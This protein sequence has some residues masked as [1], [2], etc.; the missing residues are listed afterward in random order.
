MIPRNLSVIFVIPHRACAA[1][2]KL[3][4]FILTNGGIENLRQLKRNIHCL[5]R[6]ELICLPL[7]DY[8]IVCNSSIC[9]CCINIVFF[10]FNKYLQITCHF[11]VWH[12]QYS[13][14]YFSAYMQITHLLQ[15]IFDAKNLTS[16][17]TINSQKYSIWI[18]NKSNYFFIWVNDYQKTINIKLYSA[19]KISRNDIWNPY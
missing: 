3:K 16:V 2:Q 13:S 11:D 10:C 9:I 17:V 14:R 19:V 5:F 7:V 6:C 1:S 4:F 15:N 8:S 12:I 18:S